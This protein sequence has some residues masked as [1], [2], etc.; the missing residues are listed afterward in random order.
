M[1]VI[2][3]GSKLVGRITLDRDITSSS[4]NLYTNPLNAVATGR[5]NYC[6][7]SMSAL[8]AQGEIPAAHKRIADNYMIIK[9]I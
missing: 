2:I 9:K 7:L 3:H 4:D 5:D 8:L 6:A 1:K